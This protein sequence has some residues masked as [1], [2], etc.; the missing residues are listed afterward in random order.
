MKL[1]L[2]RPFSFPSRAKMQF[3][4]L[5][6]PLHPEFPHVKCEEL[7]LG[8][9]RASPSVA[10]L[11]INRPM[12]GNAFTQAMFE[13]MERLTAWLDDN[14]ESLSVR[15]LVVC[16][17]G[18]L[19]C[20]GI[21]LGLLKDIYSKLTRPEKCP[22]TVREEFRRGIMKMQSSFTALEKLR[23]PVV[24]L[25]HG[26]CIGGGVDLITAADI[27][28]CSDSASFSVKEVDLAIVPDLGTLAR[29]PHIVGYGHAMDLSLTARTIGADEA[30]RI[31][32]VTQIIKASDAQSLLQ[33]AVSI[34][35]NLAKK[36]RL[37]VMG[38]KRMLVQSRAS[39]VT[40]DLDAVATWNSAQLI[41]EDLEKIVH[42]RSKL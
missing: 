30:L 29:L 13:E 25:I 27:R 38:T 22:G 28:V 36:P 3:D 37:A 16:S 26:P 24:I 19:F 1:Y 8:R 2:V 14:L 23:C 42:K 17:T 20:A 9:F 4:E 40:Q 15:A 34:A 31:G 7:F 39:Q 10:V 11:I 21:D 35:V 18:K 32:L 12:K 6:I 5:L 41:N 33:G